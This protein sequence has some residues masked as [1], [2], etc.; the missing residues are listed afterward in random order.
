MLY[1]TK[2]KQNVET[3]EYENVRTELGRYEY[4]QKLWNHENGNRGLYEYV[5]K[6]WNHENGNRGLYEDGVFD[7]GL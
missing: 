5:Q 3:I 2:G 7:G 6:V 4:V 1:G